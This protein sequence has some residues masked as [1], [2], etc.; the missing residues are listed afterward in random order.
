MSE[1]TSDVIVGA[2]ERHSMLSVK[3]NVGNR[4]RVSKTGLRRGSVW[5]TPR[6]SHYHVALSGEVKSRLGPSMEILF[7]PKHG[8]DQDR[9]YW[10][11]SNRD[12][13]EKIMQLFG[14]SH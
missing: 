1:F 6:N 11:L 4:H 7:G 9:I 13:L 8:D 2:V 12:V 14:R 5:V 10:K 3:I